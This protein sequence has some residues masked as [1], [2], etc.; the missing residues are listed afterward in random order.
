MRRG[1]RAPQLQRKLKLELDQAL[2][3]HRIR[4]L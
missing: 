4:N 2:I 3:H 1:N